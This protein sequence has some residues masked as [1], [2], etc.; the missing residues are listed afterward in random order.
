MQRVFVATGFL[1]DLGFAELE[2]KR[3]VESQEVPRFLP[4]F[5]C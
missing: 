4:Q 3:M 5:V 1:A 2:Q